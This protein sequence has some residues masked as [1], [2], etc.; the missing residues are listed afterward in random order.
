M[1]KGV[2]ILAIGSSGYGRWAVNFAV[3]LKYHTPD[4]DIQLICDEQNLVETSHYH[5]LF[6]RVTKIDSIDTV[7][8]NGEFFPAKAKLNLY[9]YF[10]YD[11]TAYSNVAGVIDY[12]VKNSGGTDITPVP[13]TDTSLTQILSVAQTAVGVTLQNL[14][15]AQVRA[16]MAILLYKEG[17][18]NPV[19]LQV[20]PLGQW[21]K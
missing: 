6:E 20:K 3:S 1:T 12:V 4:V 11:K 17:G 18:V 19:N 16:L 10:A 8:D 14:T 15:A 5:H 21:V 7:D 2:S 9:K 13:I